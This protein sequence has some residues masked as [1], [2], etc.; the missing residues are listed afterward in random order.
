MF[1]FFKSVYEMAILLDAE[2][3]KVTHILILYFWKIKI[4]QYIHGFNDMNI[5]DVF[6]LGFQLSSF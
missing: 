5:K 3:V 4:G 2:N 6:F 1:L